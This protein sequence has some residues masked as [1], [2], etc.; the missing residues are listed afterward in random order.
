MEESRNRTPQAEKLN[1]MP[2]L[3]VTGR[4]RFEGGDSAEDLAVIVEGIAVLN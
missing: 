4:E 3:H 1:D 2:R